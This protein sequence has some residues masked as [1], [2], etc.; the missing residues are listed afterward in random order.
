[1]PRTDSP[2]GANASVPP[3]A[4]GGR[5]GLAALLGLVPTLRVLAGLAIAA[6]IIGGLYAGRTILV[7]LALA[8]L[9]S[10]VLDPLV[11][12]LKRIG[13]PRLAAVLLVVGATLSV[14]GVTAVFVTNEARV[15]SEQ[16]PQYQNTIRKKLRSLA[17]QLR[18]PGMFE[19]AKRTLDIVQS[20]V[21]AAA[22]ALSGSSGA[23]R[24][25]VQRVEVQEPQLS[26]AQQALAAFDALKRPA[27]DA[28]L[29]LVFV[30]FILLDRVDLRDRL[31]RLLGGNLHRATDAMDEAGERISRYLIMQLT[32]NVSYGIPMALGLWA[33]GVP[34]AFLWG[35]LAGLMRFVPYVG[36]FVAALFPVTLAF[37]VHPGWSLVL[38]TIGL[39]VVLELIS[40]NIIEPWL[41]GASTGLSILSLI[42]AATFWATLW[43]PV[44]LIMSTPLTVCLLVVGRYLP[45]LA[46]LDVLLGSQPVLDEPTRIYQRMLAGDPDEAIELS[47]AQVE[48]LRGDVPAFYGQVALP[49][50]RMAMGDHMRVATP[51]HRLRL[52][53]GMDELLDDL[54]EQYPPPPPVAAASES[55][56]GPVVCLGG[57]WELDHIAARMAAHA[58]ALQGWPA[59]TRAF[60]PLTAE[61]LEGL[62][63]EDAQVVCLVWMSPEPAAAARH[64]CRRLRRRWPHVRIVLA[65][66]GE[67]LEP[68]G[69]QD[70]AQALGAD[71]LTFTLAQTLARI[72]ELQGLEL[73]R[74]FEE[75]PIPRDDAARVQALRASGVW[76]NEALRQL[77]LH[78]TKRAVDIFDVQQAMVSLVDAEMQ[79]PLCSHGRLAPPGVTE[80]EEEEALRAGMPRAL[81]PCAHVVA[82]RRPMAVADIGR[83][84]RF[85]G[86]PVLHARGVRF[87]AGAPLRDAAGH[88]LGTLCLLDSRPRA[89]DPRELRLLQAMV[90]DL[91]ASWR[92]S[93]V[94]AAPV[95]RPPPPAPSATVGQVVP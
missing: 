86:N 23:R 65:L 88:V 20:E 69:V 29:V 61:H 13:V 40:N 17:Q 83:D 44:G 4:A 6:L 46:F 57:K 18:A 42:V 7:P 63:L 55:G 90:D 35:A 84:A 74:A 60:G 38:W 31:L 5:D 73:R 71:E 52:F 91:A 50:L 8:F 33:I 2:Q 75:A 72:G 82:A 28:G 58:L 11:V 77:C 51:E 49:V 54:Q 47:V 24:R 66:W 92:G 12:R 30:I 89:F 15:L 16:L 79:R 43:G 68:G 78:T 34:G 10:F 81:S 36:A 70:D 94:A 85:A 80:A 39:I 3:S 87:Y 9:L 93:G 22:P 21:E 67:L 76:D 45:Q 14:L 95:P 32:V 19:G 25:A 64:F 1:M 27:T 37:A 41:Y 26:P 62:A 48:A 53:Q 59:Q 56:H